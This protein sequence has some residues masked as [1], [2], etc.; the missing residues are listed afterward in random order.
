MSDSVNMGR[1]SSCPV[2]DAV[3]EQKDG[4]SEGAATSVE[5]GEH[6]EGLSSWGSRWGSAGG[7]PAAP[8]GS[9][10]F[11][12]LERLGLPISLHE[13]HSPGRSGDGIEPSKRG[14]A[15]PCRL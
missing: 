13:R 7:V 6:L 10:R 4:R 5:E 3:V 2:G 8:S 9:E 11:R 12:G 15:T 1:P 14:A